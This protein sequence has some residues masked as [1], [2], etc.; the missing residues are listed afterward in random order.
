MIDYIS[1]KDK[2][3]EKVE[4]FLTSTESAKE[5]YLYH[6]ELQWLEKQY[7]GKIQVEKEEDRANHCHKYIMTRL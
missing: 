7:A 2:I 5:I 3:S 4:N 6:S 1:R